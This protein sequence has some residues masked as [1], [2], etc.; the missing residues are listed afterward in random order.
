MILKV[1]KGENI[2]VK[3]NAVNESFEEIIIFDKLEFIKKYLID[4]R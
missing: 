1:P 3:E 4:Q 2:M